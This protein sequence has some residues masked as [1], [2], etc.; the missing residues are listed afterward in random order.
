LSLHWL[1]DRFRL[2]SR[3]DAVVWRDRTIHYADLLERVETAGAFLD[4]EG[5]TAGESVLLEADFSP[6]A[7]ALLLAAIA[8]GLIVV[9]V[10]S[11][12]VNLDRD[13][14][15]RIAEASRGFSVL[16]N[17]SFSARTYPHRAEHPLLLRLR[18]EGQP[19]L[20]L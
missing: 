15:A 20:V 19:G 14:Y 2:Q 18:S 11:H 1:L 13:K 12:V 8:R 10:A 17:D 4:G 5:A 7:I 16:P 3:D 9:P 6:G